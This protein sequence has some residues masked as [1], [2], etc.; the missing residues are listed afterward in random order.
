MWN[1]TIQPNG[2]QRGMDSNGNYWNYNAGTGNYI[3]YGTG[4]MCFG[5]GA[6]R[7]CN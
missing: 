6:G 4:E 2:D 5:R 1:Q 3:N 7:F